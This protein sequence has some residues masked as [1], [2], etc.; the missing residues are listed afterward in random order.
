LDGLFETDR[1]NS[2][3]SEDGPLH[4][5]DFLIR[6]SPYAHGVCLL[7]HFE[8]GGEWIRG[9]VN[10]DAAGAGKIVHNSLEWV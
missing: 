9:K 7:L 6:T 1:Q 2:R 8:V 3:D 4:L 10:A 5:S